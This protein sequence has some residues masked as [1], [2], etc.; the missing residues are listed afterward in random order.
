[1]TERR[2][3]II[4]CDPGVDD[5][6]AL[7]YAAASQDTFE[8][9][10]VTTVSGNQTIE[11]VTRNALDLTEF[12]GLDVPVAKG[13]EGPIVR[14]AIFAPETHGETGLGLCVLPP[15]A[16]Q[17]E[18]ENAVFY[19]H[20]LL[21]E[22]PEGEKI[23]LIPTG[24]LTNIGLLLRLFPEIKNKIQEIIFMGGAANGGNIT[25]SAEYNIYSDPEAAK[26]VFHSGIPLIMC[27][28]DV[29]LKCALTRRQVA[30]L[31]QSGHTVA[32]ACGEMAVFTLENTSSKY[33]GMVSIHDVVPYMYLTHPEIFSSERAILDVDCSEGPSLGRTI[34]DFRW[35][36]HDEEETNCLVLT[37]AD[38]SKFQEYLITALYE[39]NSF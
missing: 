14:E 13:M 4:D 9:L 3:I 20:R 35:W 18:K 24:P 23:T 37:D 30:K 26:I 17:P 2:K 38:S 29:T 39:L 31:C 36:K 21:T 19:L 27:G 33:R 34:C 12:Y 10:A 8:I 22:L 16:R 11:K 15:S 25:P 5:A 32:K 1:M 6:L 7:A 28:L